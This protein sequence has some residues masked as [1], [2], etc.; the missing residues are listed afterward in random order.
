MKSVPNRWANHGLYPVTSGRMSSTRALYLHKTSHKPKAAPGRSFWTEWVTEMILISWPKWVRIRVSWGGP[1][2]QMNLW[3]T[4]MPGDLQPR[5]CLELFVQVCSLW[6][7][8]WGGLA[9]RVEVWTHWFLTSAVYIT[10]CATS[11]STFILKFILKF[12][13]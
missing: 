2:T 7:A 12:K 5:P 3:K 10:S 11:K 1:Q 9:F 6:V 8:V 4:H 13:K